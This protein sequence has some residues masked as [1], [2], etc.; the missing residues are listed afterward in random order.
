MLLTWRRLAQLYCQHIDIEL[1]LSDST[2]E[3]LSLRADRLRA[4]LPIAIH[5]AFLHLCKAAFASVCFPPTT[6]T[7]LDVKIE[8]SRH[9]NITTVSEGSR[10]PR[11]MERLFFTRAG[12]CSFQRR[13]TN[14]GHSNTHARTDTHTH[15][16]H[17]ACARFGTP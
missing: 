1:I 8:Q 10:G 6:S 14:P 2:R 12:G 11:E 3:L 4:V 15:T 5:F 9:C 7:R 16:Q 13:G 17:W